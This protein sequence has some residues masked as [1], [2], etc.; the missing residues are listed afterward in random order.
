MFIS[1]ILFI[2]LL[3]VPLCCVPVVPTPCV[4]EPPSQAFSRVIL[5]SWDGVQYNHLMELYNSG[6]LTNLRQMVNETRLPILRALITDHYTETNYGY[7]SLLSGVGQGTMQGCPDNITVWEKIEAWNS[8]WVTASIAGKSKFSDQIFP[9]ARDDVDYWYAGDVYASVVTDLAIEFVQNHSASCFFMFVH[10]REPDYAGHNYGENSQQYEDAIIECDNQAGRILSTLEVEGI[11]D[12]TAVLVTTDHGFSE[13]GTSHSGSA[14]GAPN[15][16]PN[17]YTIWIACSSGT[18]SLSEAANEYWDQNDVAPTIYSLIGLGD[19]NSRWPYIRGF[20]L[21]ERAFDLRD[22]AITSIQPST[23]MTIREPIYI[24]VFIENHGNY[25]E[26][27]TVSVYYDN[28]IIETKT[29]VYPDAPLFGY[30]RGASTTKVTFT[31]N[32]EDVSPGTYTIS[33]KA[34]VVSAEGTSQP[35]LAYTKNE[36]DTADNTL[37]NGTVTL[38]QLLTH[39]V[40]ADETPFQVITLSNSHVT[41][42]NFSELDMKISFDVTVVSGAYGFC[43][44]TI[45]K[46]LLRANATYPWKVCVDGVDRAYD[47]VENITHTFLYFTYV[48]SSHK[49]EI[50]GTWAIPE[51]PTFVHLLLFLILITSALITKTCKHKSYIAFNLLS[52]HTLRIAASLS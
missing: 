51:F 17:L 45:P 6:K 34:S 43:N 40:V 50:I 25:T 28:N 19:Y 11:N 46:M 44:V 8:S 4:G 30:S 38:Q 18:V 29:L 32:T 27:P 14:W 12:S 9:E 35:N 31:W 36:T 2:S 52:V 39:Y 42:F 1:S 41:G 47:K 22:V 21:W 48:P 3:S 10:Y 15:S 7:P 33:A 13:G 49:V 23:N 16:D 26:I 5:F 24:D 37:I 20:A